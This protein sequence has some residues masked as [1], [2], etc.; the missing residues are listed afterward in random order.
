MSREEIEAEIA[1]LETTLAQTNLESVKRML[2]KE[3]AK[4]RKQ[5]EPKRG[6]GR[7]ALDKADVY[8]REMERLEMKEAAKRD[9]RR[10]QEE[11][12]LRRLETLPNKRGRWFSVDDD[13]RVID[14][15]EYGTYINVVDGEL[16]G[17]THKVADLDGEWE[18]LS[19]SPTFKTVTR[20]ATESEEHALLTK[21][22]RARA[23]EL[24]DIGQK[25]CGNY[26]C[27]ATL[28]YVDPARFCVVCESERKFG[29]NEE[30]Q[31]L[32]K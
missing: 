32:P 21:K 11:E 1:G 22:Y 9:F 6:R 8:K 27:D 15:S 18:Y 17:A 23:N 19:P 26:K 14:V 30:K 7:P 4:L 10:R 2:E 3:L 29:Q 5:I 20:V 25:P 31:G 24:F 13:E 16:K 12:N 28:V